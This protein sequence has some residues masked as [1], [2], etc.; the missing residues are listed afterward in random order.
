MRYSIAS[1]EQGHAEFGLY[2]KAEIEARA[3]AVFPPGTYPI[4]ATSRRFGSDGETWQAGNVTVETDGTAKAV[5]T[6][7]VS[8][9]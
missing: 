1:K 3:G 5:L 8:H 7:V 2:S 4:L 9:A 6:G